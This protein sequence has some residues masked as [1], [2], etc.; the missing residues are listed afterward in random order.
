MLIQEALGT[1]VDP[2]GADEVDRVGGLAVTGVLEHRRRRSASGALGQG[3][4]RRAA[5]GGRSILRPVVPAT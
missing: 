4:G 2:D 5:G 3:G 1:E